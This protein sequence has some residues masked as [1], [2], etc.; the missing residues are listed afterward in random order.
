MYFKLA[1]RPFFNSTSR[2]LL[3][4][5]WSILA[6]SSFPSSNRE[7]RCLNCG[8]MKLKLLPIKPSQPKARNATIQLSNP[9]KH[10]ISGLML[11]IR[12]IS[13]RFKLVCLIALMAPDF[14][15]ACTSGALHLALYGC[16][17]ECYNKGSDGLLPLQY[18]DN[19][20]RFLSPKIQN[21]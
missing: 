7:R 15:S 1:Q 8:S 5:V 14:K 20:L 18:R 13:S 10:R 12:S 6:S 11:R 16:W 2:M 21:K 9:P 3:H 19:S 4:F 17:R